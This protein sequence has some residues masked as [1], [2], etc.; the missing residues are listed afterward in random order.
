MGRPQSLF[1]GGT[2]PTVPLSLR[3]C[4]QTKGY[5]QLHIHNNL[6]QKLRHWHAQRQRLADNDTHAQ[7]TDARIHTIRVGA[8]GRGAI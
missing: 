7:N 1:L 5:I 3:P 2:V 8:G 6:T 4:N